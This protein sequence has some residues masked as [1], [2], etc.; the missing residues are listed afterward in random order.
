MSIKRNLRN[1]IVDFLSPHMSQER[2]K[3]IVQAAFFGTPLHDLSFE[4]D[5][6]AF[7]GHLMSEMLNFDGVAAVSVLLETLQSDVGKTQ[8][9]QIDNFLNQL[10]SLDKETEQVSIKADN[11]F[12]IFLSSP[13]DVSDERA[14]AVNLIENLQ[15]L[16]EFR[17]L[18]SLEVVAWDQPGAPPMEANLPP[19]EAINRNMPL[20]SACDVVVVIFWKR[21]GT[22]VTLED[23]QYLSGTEF[24]Y[25]EAMAATQQ[26]GKP[27]VL[28]YRRS[29]KILFNPED[30]QFMQQVE[31][32]NRVKTFFEEEFVDETSGAM[33]GGYNVYPS[34][35]D[36]RKILESHLIQVIQQLLAAKKAS[37]TPVQKAVQKLW[38]DSPFPGLRP[39]HPVDAPIF[40]GR[41]Q[42]TDKLTERVRKQQFVAVVSASGSGKSSLVGAGLIPRL[43]KTSQKDGWLVVTT[44]P[45][46]LGTGDPFASLAASL[47]RDVD[48]QEDKLA[49]H[50]RDNPD[51]LKTLSVKMLNGD[52][53]DR[54][55]LLFIDQF[56]ELFTTVELAAR[57]PFI[58]AM[59][60]V[61]DNPQVHIVLTVRGDFYGACINIPILAKLLE[62]STFPL[63]PPDTVAL[64]E[65][66]A[67]P[68]DRAGLL[69]DDGLVRKILKDTGTDPGALALMAYALDELYHTRTDDGQLTM[70]AY[71][72][73]GGVQG[74]IGRRSEETFDRL[75][76]AEQAVLPAVFRELVSVKDDGTVTRK[77]T[78]ITQ[79]VTDDDTR[80][81]VQALT[82]A[83]LL[84]VSRGKHNQ[85]YVEVAHEALLQSWERLAEWID[86]TSED[87]R[88]LRQ[89]R[90]AAAEWD[91]MGRP[92]F[93]L[94]RHERLKPVYDMQKN[95]DVEFSDTVQAFIV[96]EMNRL[97]EQF[98]QV[99]DADMREAMNRQMNILYRL[100][101]IGDP[102]IPAIILCTS[103]RYAAGT[104]VITAAEKVLAQIELSILFSHKNKIIL[105]PDR[106]DN[107]IIEL[108]H[109]IEAR[110]QKVRNR[111]IAEQKKKQRRQ[112]ERRKQQ[113]EK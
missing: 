42:E 90:Q 59:L 11:H 53:A 77:R 46:N 30:N 5:N 93:Y 63:A 68:A 61:L 21:M 7:S 35:D 86:R 13:G 39:F 111:Q 51:A 48:I 87:L 32:Y 8:Q 76:E 89:V 31:Q 78:A 19:Q 38:K 67:R 1:Q 109:S 64:Y 80:S 95:L 43:H 71:K 75:S 66:I 18:V 25:R 6:K 72:K 41:G 36:F 94:W 74:A 55:L 23:V 110:T 15:Y 58:Q 98:K 100:I 84:V 2:R 50:L 52:V 62:N 81:F 69:F 99:R 54:R 96:P 83:R 9:K 102:A 3:A 29:E 26:T 22:P 14:I 88:L 40:F 108:A 70:E 44:T 97:M 82:Q 107:H 92:D 91:A 65:M 56:E 24:E 113:E 112:K 104:G 37:K 33:H 10:Q 106:W 73:L 103:N 20:P 101:E 12:R 45:D 4:G 105:N 27:R 57:E 28:V 79:I 49:K 85:S 34:K 16:N 60:S 47:M 17:G